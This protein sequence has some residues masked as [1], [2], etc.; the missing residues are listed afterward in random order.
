MK[1]GLS[2]FL[3][4]VMLPALAMEDGLSGVLL[5]TN[6][7]PTIHS[8]RKDVVDLLIAALCIIQRERA[9]VFN[10]PGES[11]RIAWVLSGVILDRVDQLRSKGTYVE[12]GLLSYAF[13]AL[14][15][16]TRLVRNACETG[17]EKKQALVTIPAFI[18]KDV[19]LLPADE[20]DA[21]P[22]VVNNDKIGQ[23]LLDMLAYCTQL[24]QQRAGDFEYAPSSLC[25]IL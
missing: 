10:R 2:V 18:V 19:E 14:E 24:A 13:P 4:S 21:A 20:V 1:R 25:T 3:L 6:Q 22:V 17:K 12:G 11:M 16:W 7:V 9:E 5:V 23:E 8:Q 15:N